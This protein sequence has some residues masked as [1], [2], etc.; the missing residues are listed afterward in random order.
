MLFISCDMENHNIVCLV[1]GSALRSLVG[2]QCLPGGPA[3]YHG[4][5][6][7]FHLCLLKLMLGAVAGASLGFQHCIPVTSFITSHVQLPVFLAFL[8]ANTSL[9]TWFWLSLG[10]STCALVAGYACSLQSQAPH[11]NQLTKG[12]WELGPALCTA[13]AGCPTFL[14]AE[15]VLAADS[16]HHEADGWGFQHPLQPELSCTAPCV[17]VILTHA[18]EVGRGKQL[19]KCL[20]VRFKTHWEYPQKQSSSAAGPLRVNGHFFCHWFQCKYTCIAPSTLF[21]EKLNR[22]A[23]SCGTLGLAVKCLIHGNLLRT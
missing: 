3:S 19:R 23:C 17:W 6:S 5:C 11:L 9:Q 1:P 14:S 4:Q 20:A 12:A 7:L 10:R 2:R 13:V 15:P 21:Q 22:R 18:E 16:S 8:F